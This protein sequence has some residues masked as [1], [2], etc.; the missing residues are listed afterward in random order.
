MSAYMWSSWPVAPALTLC[1]PN[2]NSGATALLPILAT[3]EC[4]TQHQS[5]GAPSSWISQALAHPQVLHTLGMLSG[6]A[7][8]QE[9]RCNSLAHPTC[10]PTTT[11]LRLPLELGFQM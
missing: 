6:V 8:R 5:L 11:V 2:L 1:I 10:L 3:A 9:G 7:G 4:L